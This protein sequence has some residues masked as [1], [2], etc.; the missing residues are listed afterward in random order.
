LLK[1]S[2]LAAFL[3]VF[4]LAMAVFLALRS[5]ASLSYFFKMFS[6]TAFSAGAAGAAYDVCFLT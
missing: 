4:D 6:G 1:A 5:F 3:S 2:A